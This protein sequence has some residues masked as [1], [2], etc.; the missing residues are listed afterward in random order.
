MLQPLATR[1]QDVHVLL[2]KLDVGLVADL[3]D[4]VVLG[5][6]V[7]DLDE[8]VANHDLVVL[9]VAHEAGQRDLAGQHALLGELGALG[10]QDQDALVALG[11]VADTGD[12]DL[13][14]LDGGKAALA[15]LLGDGAAQE[16]GLSDEVGHELVHGVVVD[17]VRVANLSTTPFFMMMMLSESAMASDW[18]CV[19]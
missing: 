2:A 7:S 10:T 14:A 17:G 8:G 18:S 3:E 19:T 4:L 13:V 15:V 12:L 16:V 1:L 9:V 5:V 11:E 6:E